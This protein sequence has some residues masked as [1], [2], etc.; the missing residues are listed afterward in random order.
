MVVPT[1]LDIGLDSPLSRDLIGD[2]FDVAP[3]PDSILEV[4]SSLLQLVS[5][6]VSQSA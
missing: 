4:L 1:A 6:L 5:K 2:L 3:I